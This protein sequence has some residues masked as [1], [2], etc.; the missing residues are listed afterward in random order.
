MRLLRADLFGTYNLQTTYNVQPTN[1]VCRLYVVGQNGVPRLRG[2]DK[3]TTDNRQTRLPCKKCTTYNRQPRPDVQPTTD[4]HNRRPT[5]EVF[6][7]RLSEAAPGSE[8]WLDLPSPGP[9]TC[10]LGGVGGL[11]VSPTVRTGSSL[12]WFWGEMQSV[13]KKGRFSP[14]P[15]PRTPPAVTPLAPAP[16][17]T[18]SHQPTQACRL[19]LVG[20]PEV[21]GCRLS[22]V[23]ATGRRTSV[24][25]CKSQRGA[26]TFRQNGCT[27]YNVHTRFVGCGSI[28]ADATYNV[29][30]TNENGRNLVGC[31]LSL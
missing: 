22:V 31:T 6:V 21:V 27:T 20:R 16:R 19:S 18:T 3:S 25:G 10:R 24:V 12:R 1:N 17:L 7:G 13:P 26:D 14:S 28:L 23:A 2:G 5:T 4:E 11:D 15:A 30:P 9:R 29:Q 8:P